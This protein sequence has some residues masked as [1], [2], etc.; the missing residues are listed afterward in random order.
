M[1]E[2]VGEIIVAGDVVGDVVGTAEIVV[3]PLV[4]LVTM[5]NVWVC[6]GIETAVPYFP[7]FQR[8]PDCQRANIV[9]NEST[10]TS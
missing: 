8:G 9:P 2:R 1:S 10:A 4:C 7:I 3:T 5:A 6:V